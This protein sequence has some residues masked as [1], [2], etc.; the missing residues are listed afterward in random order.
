M[1]QN[2]KYIGIYRYN[3]V[4]I[5]NG[6]P[7]IIEKTLFDRAQERFKTNYAARARKKAVADYLLTGKIFCGHC[8]ANMVGE[9]GTARNG[10]TYYYYKCTSRKRRTKTCDKNTEHKGWIEEY[11][12][13]VTLAQL[14]DERIEAI[15]TKAS[16]LLIKEAE[17]SSL[18]PTLKDMLRDVEKRIKNIIDLMEQGIATLSTK[19]RLLEL[20]SQKVDLTTRIATEDM[21]KPL[22]SKERIMFW[23][24]SFKSGD[25]SD[26]EYRRRV[27]DTLLNSIYVYDLNGG[28]GRRLIFTFNISGQN[29]TTIDVS[30]I[31]CFAP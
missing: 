10:D 25:T 29:T 22:L 30:D 20:E 4:V 6:V 19:E 12:V 2:D 28:K 16:E 15:A 11:A 24:C 13:R 14:T 5:E 18:L 3:D 26:P 1:L 8:G 7:A 31:A 9:S 23:L 17:E 21:K 27:I